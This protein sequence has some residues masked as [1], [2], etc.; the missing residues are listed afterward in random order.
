MTSSAETL[1]ATLDGTA[2]R[3]LETLADTQ[4]PTSG[5]ALASALGVSPTTATVT[6]SRLRNAGFVFSER[7][8]RADLWR[9]NRANPLI[10]EW[11]FETGR[12]PMP[13]N[14]RPQGRVVILTAKPEEYRA[15]IAHL[16]NPQPTRVGATRY[17]HGEFHGA[18]IDWTA[19]VAE[20][21]MG[22]VDTSAEVVAA[23]V[24]FE[25]HLV[26]FVGVAA[27]VKPDD[28]CRGDVVV[29][30][31]AYSVHAGKDIDEGG[32]PVTLG[33][34]IGPPA[35]YALVQLATMV[36]RGEWAREVLLG[37]RPALNALGRP[38]T[39]EIKAIAAGEVVE[40]NVKSALME[41]IRSQFDNV[42]ALDMESFGL[43][44][45]AHRRGL[46]ALAIRGISDSVGDKNAQ[47][48]QE[49]QPV[50]SAH[51]AGFAFALLRAAEAQDLGT[52]PVTVPV[53]GAP[54]PLGTSDVV[55][56]SADEA[57]FKL[58]PSVA[59]A[60]EAAERALGGRASALVVELAALEDRWDEWLGRVRRNPP[61][62]LTAADAGPLWVML[63][64]Y[65]EAHVHSTAVWL[66]EQAAQRAANAPTR[67]VLLS[68][69]ALVAA[70]E[71]TLEA[72]EGLLGRAATLRPDGETLWDLHRATIRNDPHSMLSTISRLL[73]P[74][75]LGFLRAALPDEAAASP[76]ADDG[77]IAFLDDFAAGSPELFEELR[78]VV[79]NLA[80]AAL[81]TAN[82]LASAQLLYETLVD[83]LP[84]ARPPSSGNAVRGSLVGPRT[85]SVIS[86]LART[87]LTRVAG[88][89]GPEPGL[90]KG[91]ALAT[92][93]ELALTA[94]D[95]MRD[96]FGP[97]A[98]VLRMAAMA[99]SAAG[100]PRG[101][102]ALLLPPPHGTARP[103]EFSAQPVVSLA[104]ELAATTRQSELAFSL[105]K[106]IEDGVERHIA[107]GLA[108]LGR[109]DCRA[110]AAQEFRAALH[111]AA[112]G[113]RRDQQVRAVLGLSFVE[114]PT[115]DELALVDD[116]DRATADLIRAQRHAAAGRSLQAQLITRQYPPSEAT[117]EIRVEL[118]LADGKVEEA[119]AVLEDY[120]RENNDERFLVQ[121]ATLAISADHTGEAERIARL[122]AASLDAH[123]RRIA[124]EILIDVASRSKR[125]DRVLAETRRLLDDPDIAKRDPDRAAHLV[126]YRWARAEAHYQLRQFPD[127]YEAVQK[128]PPLVAV[129][130]GQARLVLGVLHFVAPSVRELGEVE[131]QSPCP[132]QAEVLARLTEIA[133]A[134][135]DNEE[136]VA[137]A[138]MT[139]LQLP[140]EEI[141]PGQLAMARAL[142]QQFFGRF[143]DSHLIRQVPLRDT[144]ADVTE[145]LRGTLA[146]G[147]EEAIARRREA[148]A[149][150]IPLSVF[151]AIVRRSYSEALIK[152][153]AACYM[154]AQA[155][156]EV[157]SR[158]VA[159][160]ASALNGTVVVD[161]SSLFL[162]HVAFGDVARLRSHFDRFLLGGP[163]RDDILAAR[164]ALQMNS[165]FSMG[166]DPFTN[167]P[168][169]E[170]R[171]DATAQRW[172][173]DGERLAAALRLCEVVPEPLGEGDHFQRVWSASILLAKDKGVAL[174]ADDAALRVTARSEGVSAFSSLQV[175]QALVMAGEL[176]E[177][178]LETA[179]R[180]LMVIRAA[181]LPLPGGVLGIAA[182]ENWS[183]HGYAAFMLARPATWTPW[184]QGLAI[185]ID[186]IKAIPK[187]NP[188][189]LAAWCGAA[190]FGLCQ[191]IPNGMVPIAAGSLVA[192]TVVTAKQAELLP[193]ALDV[194][195]P[196]I[197]QFARDVDLLRQVVL[198]VVSTFRQL[199]PE[200]HL[201]SVVLPLFQ[202]LDEMRRNE[203]LRTFFTAP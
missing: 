107:T 146:A 45:A 46:P 199:V 22:N 82:Q 174:L 124:G 26:L 141:D 25:P 78:F 11:L 3:A 4:G 43:Y 112:V 168:T 182:E 35:P 171:D 161:T 80:G 98:E 118:L 56:G 91:R 67:T 125:W 119:I 194:C 158:E 29:G 148:W 181:E 32:R 33:R 84:S 97:T 102:L 163:Q 203:A 132:T 90:D 68:R 30:S 9:V 180:Q 41:R 87:L 173:S 139:S 105:A 176:E 103:E 189:D 66:Y 1:Q 14:G 49:W 127:A 72:A 117:V 152:N 28:L 92:A 111:G 166:W 104:A 155:D 94:R 47:D 62:S 89:Q 7:K 190:L 170:R 65:A 195:A 200:Q 96:W 27:S 121:A 126:A 122:F 73:L 154:I 54:S 16:N 58:P 114:E 59:V 8:G 21:G 12:V 69:A 110:E 88:A 40:R 5:R 191:A 60:Y 50:A 172:A 186:L 44:E 193:I 39:V 197:A 101:A 183:P 63:A 106:R 147:A 100:D 31:Q 164:S 19:Y 42:A 143:P 6:L 160:A 153:A 55:A 131:V 108:Y 150:K 13:L 157:T 142:Q 149:G 81:L 177:S 113:N 77:L 156:P 75:D 130:E 192:W 135:P 93:L 184:Q 202:G 2:Y 123:R 10:G 79:A 165:P 38:P 133:Q 162:A 64:A 175:L 136:I 140:V 52:M 23:A 51:A 37:V 74:L 76:A 17:E 198:R 95:R 137:A 179:Y 85:A 70:R 188:N 178:V 159:A 18:H 187:P 15:V 167:R 144:V 34:P 61:P 169:I 138:V 128:D 71:G 48:D 86:Q 196:V 116:V 151:A 36:R 99:Q 120:A 201:G 185:Y 83:G 53:P 24:T 20:S 129:N 134:F 115:D 57:L 145:L 109:G